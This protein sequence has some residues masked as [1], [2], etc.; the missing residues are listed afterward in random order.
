ML[1]S[2]TFVLFTKISTFSNSDTSKLINITKITAVHKNLMEIT[3]TES[4]DNNNTNTKRYGQ[5][6]TER[7]HRPKIIPYLK[8]MEK[9]PIHRNHRI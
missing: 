5:K 6:K 2:Y 1:I 3:D 9:V 8:E 7:W 4:S